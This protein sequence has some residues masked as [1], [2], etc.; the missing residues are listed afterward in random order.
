MPDDQLASLFG[1]T[2]RTAVIVGATGG[3]GTEAA[4]GLSAA[5]ANVGLIARRV[6]RLRAL[7][8]EI[9]GGTGVRTCVAAGDVTDRASIAGALDH[10]ERELGPVWV[11]VYAAGIARLRRAELHSRTDWDESIAVN[12]TGAFETAQLVGARMIERGRG[13][14]IVMIS[15][16]AGLGGNSVHRHVGYS[17]SKGGL[18]LLVRQ[19]AV[20]WA[21]HGITVNAVA[22]SYFPTEMTIDP[23]THA[24]PE[25]MRTRIEQFT[26]MGRLG[27]PGELRTAFCFL[28]AP[29]SSYVTGAIVTVDGGWSAW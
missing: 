17:A 8:D 6:E 2:G 13:G 16:V 26:P 14:R 23:R 7:A 29:A 1:L 12:L 5:G 19:M 10:V 15:S 4:Q 20:E 25:D 21:R 18:N 9:S 24:V 3:L 22:P 27:A 28:A 11:L